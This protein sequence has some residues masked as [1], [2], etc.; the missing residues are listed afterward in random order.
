[1]VNF[2]RNRKVCVFDKEGF[3]LAGIKMNHDNAVLAH[4]DKF[5]DPAEAERL[6][7]DELAISKGRMCIFYII[8][9][10]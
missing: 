10:I 6:V 3:G 8:A 7:P 1:M 5:L 2:L 9:I 4:I